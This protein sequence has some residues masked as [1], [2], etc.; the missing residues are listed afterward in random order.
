MLTHSFPMHP[1]S[2]PENIRK[3]YGFF[4]KDSVLLY[5]YISRFRHNEITVYIVVIILT[6]MT[7]VLVFYWY[8]DHFPSQYR[9]IGR[10]L[11]G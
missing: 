6:F 4:F 1:F 3:T 2:T 7:Y 5:L 8:G 9:D 11:N 10:Y